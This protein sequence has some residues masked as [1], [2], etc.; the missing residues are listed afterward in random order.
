MA[1]KEEF[2]LIR[3]EVIIVRP[4]IYEQIEEDKRRAIKRIMAIVDTQ[5]VDTDV[6]AYIRKAVL[7]ACNDMA[8]AFGLIMERIVSKYSS[9]SIILEKKT[10]TKKLEELGVTEDLE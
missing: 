2:K 5:V 4:T 8:R 6:H 10:S 1:N 9:E 3:R 7:D